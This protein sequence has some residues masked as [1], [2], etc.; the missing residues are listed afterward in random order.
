[1]LK[2]Y[3]YLDIFNLSNFAGS[4]QSVISIWTKYYTDILCF[5][6][7]MYIYN[8]SVFSMMHKHTYICHSNVTLWT[9]V[10]RHLCLINKAIY[11]SVY[12]IFLCIVFNVPFYIVP[13]ISG[14]CLLVTEGT[15][16]CSYYTIAGNR[17][18][19]LADY[20]ATYTVKL[21]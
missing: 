17:N 11:T 19:K 9:V 7:I 8:S 12:N 3:L 20:E 4:L 6:T 10:D 21:W 16:Q 2:L 1:M 18:R 13:I 5:I 14:Q 15:V